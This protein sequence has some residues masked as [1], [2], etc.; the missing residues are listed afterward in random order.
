MFVRT[1]MKKH[2]ITITPR[3][4]ILEAWRLMKEH[5]FRHLP[6]VEEGKLVGIIT[7]RDIRQALPAPGA[8]LSVHKL[9]ECLDQRTVGETMTTQ[10]V[11]IAPEASVKEAARLLLE[12]RIGGLPVVSGEELV[13]IITEADLLRAFLQIAEEEIPEAFRGPDGS[14]WLLKLLSG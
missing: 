7:D 6:V 13:G 11:T 9:R 10:V 5:H 3:A 1:W 14:A 2:P 8:T 4:S 12:H